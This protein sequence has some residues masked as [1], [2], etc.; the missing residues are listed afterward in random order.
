[1]NK[2][3][4]AGFLSLLLIFVFCLAGCSPNK[5]QAPESKTVTVTDMAGRQVVIPTP[6]NQAVAIGPGSLRLYCYVNGIEKIVGVENFEKNNPTGRPYALANPDLKNLPVIGTGGPNSSPDAEKLVEVKP[7]VIFCD[8]SLDKAAADSLQSKTGIPVIVLSYGSL[9]TFDNTIFDSLAIIGQVMGEEKRAQEVIDYIKNCQQDLRDRVKDVAEEEK[10]TV[11]VGAM[12][13][14][15]SHGIQ[16]TQAK[17]PPF[18]LLRAK[19]VVDET[20]KT[21]SVN[22]DLEK[23]IQW[24]PDKIFI[25][26]A[27]YDLV[28]QDFKKN[29]VVYKSLTAIKNGE[30]YGQMPFNF[31]TSNIDTALADT[32][33]I[34]KILYPKHFKDVD[35]VKKADEIYTY[36]VGKPIYAEM[37]RDFGGFGKLTLD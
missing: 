13:M 37:A 11:Y 17:Y 15:G 4:A 27:G 7:G 23:L 1:M 21:G 28:Q 33:Y 34:G 24:N 22:I 18:V 12:G 10:P 14:K 19:N 6:V 2:K 30:V 8:S 25:D 32:Y 31:Y 3:T 26:E 9:G 35:P 5:T 36:L 29:P 16:S 20:G